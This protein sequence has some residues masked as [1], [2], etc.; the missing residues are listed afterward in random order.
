MWET[1]HVSLRKK[2]FNERSSIKRGIISKKY[3]KDGKYYWDE[4][5]LTNF[6]KNIISISEKSISLLSYKANKIAL[7]WVKYKYCAE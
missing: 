7:N 5:L 2:R 4:L 1:Y 3:S 6:D